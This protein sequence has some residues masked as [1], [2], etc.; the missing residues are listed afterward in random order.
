MWAT[1]TKGE[2]PMNTE[3]QGPALEFSELPLSMPVEADKLAESAN[4]TAA[5]ATVGTLTEEQL[6][7][8]IARLWAANKVNRYELGEKLWQLKQQAKH[9]QWMMKVDHMGIKQRTVNSLMADYREEY[10]RRNPP[11]NPEE[12]FEGEAPHNDT[13]EE[14]SGE[15]VADVVADQEGHTASV[16]PSA[17]PIPVAPVP[18]QENAVK[19]EGKA[20]FR[21]H[22]TLTK[23]AEEKVWNHAI[24]VIIREGD[25]VN[26]ESEAALFAVVAV[27]QE[28]ER[29][30]QQREIAADGDGSVGAPSQAESSTREPSVLAAVTVAPAPILENLIKP[31][32]VPVPSLP[33]TPRKPLQIVDEDEEVQ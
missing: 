27:A 2:T 20:Y 22:I 28:L 11:A 1:P 26:N 32:P 31:V 13:A 17:Q 4:L 23:G 5:E 21:P 30:Q 3:T 29:R 16:D 18:T 19:P 14:K 33:P 7:A 24:D 8:E 9:G 25:D 6:Y 10:M 12:D 15:P